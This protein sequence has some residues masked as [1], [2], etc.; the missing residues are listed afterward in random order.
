LDL[1][2][3]PLAFSLIVASRLLYPYNTD[4]KTSKLK[5]KQF[6]IGGTPR[7][8]HKVTWGR[9]EGDRGDQEKTGCQKG[10]EQSS[11]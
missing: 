2:L 9:E 10:R 6:S 8:F 11:Q 7:E 4:D 5:V 3:L 1:I